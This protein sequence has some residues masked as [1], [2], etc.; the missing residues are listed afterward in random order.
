MTTVNDVTK[1]IGDTDLVR[2]QRLVKP[3]SANIFVKM[4]SRNPGGSVYYRLREDV[5]GTDHFELRVFDSAEL[6]VVDGAVASAGTQT[7]RGL[8][9]AASRSLY[10]DG[11][12]V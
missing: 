1:L 10:V 7:I 6:S 12:A 2:L 4:E 9:S 3:N 5:G 11:V 8:F